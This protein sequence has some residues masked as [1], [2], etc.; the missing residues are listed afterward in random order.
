MQKV[1][2]HTDLSS[3][4]VDRLGGGGY[5]GKGRGRKSGR[6]DKRSNIIKR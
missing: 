1:V 4:G 2:T 6:I 3:S 5:G